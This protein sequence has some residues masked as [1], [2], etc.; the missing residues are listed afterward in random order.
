M[1]ARNRPGSAAP[2]A[3]AQVSRG[4]DAS[5][6]AA[7]ASLTSAGLGSAGGAGAGVGVATQRDSPEHSPLSH[8]L[9]V[10][11]AALAWVRVSVLMCGEPSGII[12]ERTFTVL[13]SMHRLAGSQACPSPQSALL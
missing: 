11:Q 13:V 6:S 7:A 10:L 3:L 2:G 4:V 1:T 5:G 8:A 12:P 9:A